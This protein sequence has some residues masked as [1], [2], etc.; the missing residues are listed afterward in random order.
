MHLDI[1]DSIPMPT[2]TLTTN[3]YHI[4][5]HAKSQTDWLTTPGIPQLLIEHIRM[6]R[7]LSGI[8]IHAFCIV[9]DHLELLLSA[10]EEHPYEWAK[11]FMRR[12]LADVHLFAENSD[13]R[14]DK[15]FICEPVYEGAEQRKLAIHIEIDAPFGPDGHGLWPWTGI[16]FPHLLDPIQWAD[17]PVSNE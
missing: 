16:C 10:G 15:N 1:M 6:C 14:W 11:T 3:V 17:V 4:E 2:T 5:L 9:A 8:R 12:T 7:V 13:M